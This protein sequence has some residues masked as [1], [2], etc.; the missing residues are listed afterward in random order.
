MFSVSVTGNYV[1]PGKYEIRPMVSPT[2]RLLVFFSVKTLYLTLKTTPWYPSG[3][4]EITFNVIVGV[5]TSNP[6]H[7][8]PSPWVNTWPIAQIVLATA[9]WTLSQDSIRGHWTV[10]ETA[11]VTLI[12]GTVINHGTVFSYRCEVEAWV[13]KAH[14]HCSTGVIIWWTGQHGSVVTTWGGWIWVICACVAL[15]SNSCWEIG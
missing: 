1:L 10:H 7:P 4:F 14:H 9:H 2:N 12:A 5:S 15:D 13:V 3:L 6:L 11:N 8:S